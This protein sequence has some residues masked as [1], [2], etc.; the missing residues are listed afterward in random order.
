MF[1]HIWSPACRVA[2]SR[3]HSPRC[4]NA[5]TRTA[6]HSHAAFLVLATQANADLLGAQAFGSNF[7]GADLS[8]ARMDQSEFKY[9]DFRKALMSEAVLNSAFIMC[10]IASAL[11]S[12]STQPVC[13]IITWQCLIATGPF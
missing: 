12:T 2:C 13:K 5:R 11:P 3:A 1:A 10:A 7:V 9:C 8:H 4:A 6:A